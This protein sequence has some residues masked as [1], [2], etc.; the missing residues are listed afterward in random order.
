MSV[1]L[2]HPVW[3][4]L[5]WSPQEMN[6]SP[7]SCS[8][9]FPSERTSLFLPH[10]F[11]LWIL[12]LCAWLGAG[13][14]RH[15]RHVCWIRVFVPLIGSVPLFWN[16]IKINSNSTWKF[17]VKAKGHPG[18]C[19]QGSPRSGHPG[20][21]SLEAWQSALAPAARRHC[22]ADRHASSWAWNAGYEMSTG[23][24]IYLLIRTRNVNITSWKKRVSDS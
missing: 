20:L 22:C 19:V 15:P 16:K 23:L 24:E 17:E 10:A 8:H 9:Q 18:R 2:S 14:I 21:I 5:L 1:I 13:S 4:P 12:G 6:L 7:P 11:A 3:G